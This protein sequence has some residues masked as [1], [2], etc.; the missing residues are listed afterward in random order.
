[1]RSTIRFIV[2][3][4]FCALVGNWPHS[5]SG[6]GAEAGGLTKN[7]PRIRSKA[8]ISGDIRF[9]TANGGTGCPRRVGV[10]G[11]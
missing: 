5:G 2:A 9:T 8:K 3:A 7:R 10:S 11:G 1:M 6:R 4:S